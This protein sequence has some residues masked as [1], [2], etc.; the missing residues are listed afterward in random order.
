MRLNDLIKKTFP[1][2]GIYESIVGTNGI[3]KNL[4]P[5][6]IVKT[7]NRL[8]MKLYK[9]TDTIKNLAIYPFCSVNIVHDPQLFY[10]TLIGKE[11]DYKIKYGLP[12]LN[13]VTIYCKCEKELEGNPSVFTLN[14]F[15]YEISDNTITAFNRGSALFIDSL[16]H[17]TR[18]DIVSEEIKE[19]IIP[20][21][22][23]EIEI[24]RKTSPWLI[25]YLEEIDKI[26]RSKRYKLDQ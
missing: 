19:E 11:I 14:P 4:S 22:L 25:Q 6:G 7:E 15:D 20:I 26:V 21:I 1:N 18:L 5:I 13:G 9:N 8:I 16:V 23:Y 2:D 24:S 12:S 17:F 3:S 10:L